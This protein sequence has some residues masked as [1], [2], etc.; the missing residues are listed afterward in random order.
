MDP[1]NTPASD[2]MRQALDDTRELVKLE[3]ALARDEVRKDLLSVRTTAIAAGV[4]ALCMILALSL[5]LVALALAIDIGAIAPLVIGLVLL[6]V[7][8]SSA[9]IAYAAVPK[10][11]VSETQKRIQTDVKL[12]KEHVTP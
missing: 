2:L 3:V 1:R 6:V 9:G 4:A 12:V 8:G 7:A 10:K 11:P 5:L